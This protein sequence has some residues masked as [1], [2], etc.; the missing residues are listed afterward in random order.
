M[1]FDGI[2]H[3]IAAMAVCEDCEQEMLRAQTCKARSLMSFRDETFKPIAYGSETIWPMGFT[4]ACG[5]C[6]VAPGGTHHFGC[7][8]EQCPRCGDQLISCDCAEE[9]DLHLAPN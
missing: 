2:R 7:D 4:G 8:I 9:F 5:D 3:S 6:G 1:A